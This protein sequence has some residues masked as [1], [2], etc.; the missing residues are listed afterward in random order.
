MY[1]MVNKFMYSWSFLSN[2]YFAKHLIRLTSRI[3][4]GIERKSVS[5]T[6]KVFW[7]VSWSTGV[8]YYYYL[9]L[10]NGFNLNV[11][12]FFFMLNIVLTLFSASFVRCWSWP[13]KTNKCTSSGCLMEMVLIVIRWANNSSRNTNK[14]N[15]N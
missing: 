8:W 14:T 11:V 15:I 1:Y 13:R 10:L 6:A 4:I 3:S 12:S 9:C 5:P 7:H 2:K